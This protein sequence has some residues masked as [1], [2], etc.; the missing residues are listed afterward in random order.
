[1]AF[2]KHLFDVYYVQ[3]TLLDV[4]DT[5]MKDPVPNLKEFIVSKTQKNEITSREV[6]TRQCKS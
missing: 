5:V 1:M 4:V 2:I 6:C 3:G